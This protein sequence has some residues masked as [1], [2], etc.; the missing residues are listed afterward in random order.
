MRDNCQAYGADRRRSAPREGLALLQG[1]LI[2]GRCGKRM[3][4]RYHSRRGQLV[5]DY[6]CQREGIEHGEPVCQHVPGAAIDDK[7]GELLV[8]ALTPVTIDVALAVQG[9]L[10]TRLEE[11]DRLRQQQVERARYEAE[12][13]RRRYLRVD[14]DHRL[15]A[16]SLEADWNAKLKL[17]AEA[18]ES[19]DRQ[20]SEDRRLIDERQR[21]AILAL[22]TTFP[23]LWR[24]PATPDRER[25]RMVRL[26]LEDVT[27]VREDHQLAVHVRFKGGAAR[28]I[29]L[30][31]PQRSWEQRQTNPEVVTT[32]DRLLNHH[33]YPEIAAKL[34][35][36]GSHSGEGLPF[37]A[38]IVARIQRSYGLASRYDRLRQAGM[39]TVEEIAKVLGI[40]PQS[41]T[42]WNRAGL[43]RGHAFN[44]K[45]DCLYEPPGD[46]APQ[47]AHGV[48]LSKRAAA[49]AFALQGAQEAQ[50][51]A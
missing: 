25:K 46:N 51:E 45:N 5:P 42:K 17:V 4:V 31:L 3:T 49:R 34:N 18:Q 13:A 41:V 29:Q 19:C 9:E 21:A 24:D 30:P 27:L 37:T 50:Y 39:L 22:S 8:E 6:M 43:L 16:D 14:P 36:A 40:H 47:K 32:I 33:P 23:Q 20:R 48:K 12:L 26:L 10:Q 38:R 35:E 28:S 1:L 15:V 11:A 2:C 7:V 44:G